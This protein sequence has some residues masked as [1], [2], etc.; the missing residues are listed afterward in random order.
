MAKYIFFLPESFY[1]EQPY[2]PCIHLVRSIPRLGLRY[3]TKDRIPKRAVSVQ[4]LVSVLLISTAVVVVFNFMSVS[5]WPRGLLSSVVFESMAGLNRSNIGA[6]SASSSTMRMILRIPLENFSPNWKV[7]REARAYD[8]Y[9]KCLCRFVL[10]N[11][12]CV[13]IQIPSLS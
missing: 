7:R 12:Y 10:A 5:N 3:R 6:V 9:N 1:A 2:I 4:I 8:V 11:V 13:G